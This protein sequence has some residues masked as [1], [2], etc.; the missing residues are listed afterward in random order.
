MKALVFDLLRHP[1]SVEE[2]TQGL[3]NMEQKSE[4]YLASCL[5]I[6]PDHPSEQAH[7]DNLA[8]A[9]KLPPDLAKQLQ[10]QANQAMAE[11]A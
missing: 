10:W 11:A 1:I 9:L 7:L 4:L 3:E 5:V 6:N 8:M 2:I